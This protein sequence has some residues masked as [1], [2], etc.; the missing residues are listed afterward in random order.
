VK[1]V[2]LVTNSVTSRVRVSKSK[3]QRSITRDASVLFAR[4]NTGFVGEDAAV[5]TGLEV[6]LEVE[7][8]VGLEAVDSDDNEDEDAAD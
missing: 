5:N 7:V 8:E 1:G 6:G 3:P 4:D 2:A